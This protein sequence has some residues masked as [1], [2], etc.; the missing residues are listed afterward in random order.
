MQRQKGIVTLDQRVDYAGI[1]RVDVFDH[2]VGATFYQLKTYSKLEYIH[3]QGTQITVKW[4][5]LASQEAY[6][7]E[8]HQPNYK[9]V[10]ALGESY[11]FDYQTPGGLMALRVETDHLSLKEGSENI[12]LEVNYR[13]YQQ[14]QLMGNY[15]YRLIYQG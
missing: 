14:D 4:Y 9:L 10:F 1:D 11:H 13:I 7:V 5:R 12:D 6:Q 2:Q 8:I 3:P 15:H